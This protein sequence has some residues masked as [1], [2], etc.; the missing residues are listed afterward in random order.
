MD[1][2]EIAAETRHD[3]GKGASRRLRRDGKIPAI[4]YGAGNDPVP[5]QL[6]HNDMLLHTDHEAFYS[7][8]LTLT[9]DGKAEPVVLKDMQRHP[10]KR[11]I[12]HMDFQRVDESEELTMRVPIHFLNEEKCAG[13]KSGG[14]VI[15]HLMSDLEIS[16]LPKDLPEYIEIDVQHLELGD[17]IHLSEIKVPEGV[18]LALLSG[19]SD[20]DL[21]VVSVNVP[22]VAEEDL[23][24]ETEE[25]EEAEGAAEAAEG[26]EASDE[27][28]GDGEGDAD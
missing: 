7:H 21:P 14:G 25:G 26:S 19:A 12:M 18:T 5:I 8:I 11:A 6:G 28:E 22:R 15:S 20:D 10:Y 4:I 2:F 9:L 27:A 3:R 17:A 1:K 16:C 23:E 13:V 24:A